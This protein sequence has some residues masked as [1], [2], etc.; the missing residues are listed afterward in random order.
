MKI[1]IVE[2][3]AWEQH[4]SS[5][6]D[7][8]HRTERLIGNPP[9]TEAWL[10]NATVCRRLSISKRTLQTLSDTDK[11]P[12]SM[13][14]HK[15]YYKESDITEA[16]NS[17]TECTMAE[18]EIITSDNPQMQLFTQIMEGVLANLERYYSS[19]RP[20]LG[21]EVFL[22]GEEV[23]EHPSSAHAHSKSTAVTGH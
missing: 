14:V 16:L 5:F 11:I 15:C 17:K 13:V 4:C 22:S 19:A 3:K 1:I 20:M 12:F 2:G 18:N 21:G 8:I 23:C 9:Q 7:F 6:A 10:D